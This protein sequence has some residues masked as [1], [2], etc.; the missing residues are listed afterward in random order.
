MF[1]SGKS[2]DQ[3]IDARKNNLDII[4][5][6][7]ATLVI[8]SHAYP[9]TT[10]NNATEAFAVFSNGQMTFG[11]LAVSIFFVISGFLITQ[12]Y[13][14]SKNPIYYFKARVLRIFPGL[15][16]CVLL[17]VLFLGPILSELGVKAYFTNRETFDYLK[18]I[19]LYWIQYDLPGVFQTNAWPG[20][21]NG[22]LWTLWYEFFFYIVVAVLGVARL[23]DKRVV[24]AGFILASALY[25]LGKGALY[26]DLFRY[27]GAGMA[28][29]LFRKQIKLNGW[30][31]LVSL[32]ILFIT[33]KA[34]YFVYAFT[35]FGTYLIFYV[36]FDTRVK[37][38][39]FG[40]YGDFSYGIYIYAFPIQQIMSYLFHNQLNVWGNF[41]LTF[42]LALLL[43]I[44][45]WYLVEKRALKY[46]K[47]TLKSLWLKWNANPKIK[48]I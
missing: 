21:V 20:A 4:R 7:A 44:I 47:V 22:S 39:N 24:L 36:A 41:L 28:L 40:R 8:F 23:L 17:T 6:I 14:R 25:F 18:T 30:M 33:V 38:Q 43:A 19:T 48:Q 35:I 11:E 31:A 15:I 1:L 45:S 32:V 13:D 3:C 42:P 2:I 12:S 37:L 5:F 16:F 34:G 10:G 46:K 9:L 27:F 29:Y 26:T